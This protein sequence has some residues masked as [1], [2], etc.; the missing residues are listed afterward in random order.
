MTLLSWRASIGLVVRKVA[1]ALALVYGLSFA[2]LCLGTCLTMPSEPSK[3]AHAC[4]PKPGTTV[5]APAKDCCATEAGTVAAK[6][7]VAGSAEFAV[8]PE[9]FTTVPRFASRVAAAPPSAPS[10]PLVLRI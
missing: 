7:M 5:S 6:P 3:A 8:V 4:C 1:A 2:M 9:A 10:P